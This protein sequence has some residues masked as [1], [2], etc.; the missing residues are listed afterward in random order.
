METATPTED[1][2][3]RMA[4]SPASPFD[5]SSEAPSKPGGS[6]GVPSLSQGRG[7]L[8]PPFLSVP[9]GEGGMVPLPVLSPGSLS[10]PLRAGATRRPS[11]SPP[12]PTSMETA[13]PAEDPPV[14]IAT[15]SA[16][17]FDTS[18]EA[19]SKPGG[20]SGVPS[21]SRGRG[22][23]LPPFLS[24]PTGAGGMAGG[25]RRAPGH[26]LI[27][28]VLEFC[29]RGYLPPGCGVAVDFCHLVVGVDT[30]QPGHL[31]KLFLR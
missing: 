4:T 3:V 8:L 9:T 21:L 11:A 25:G 15:S 31:Q 29:Q 16:S 26:I 27:R 24:V 18:S 7:G 20:S 6:G 10:Y 17:P 2:P 5:T 14:R 23:L 13:T 12:V 19:P 28:R 22:G 1:P 30:P